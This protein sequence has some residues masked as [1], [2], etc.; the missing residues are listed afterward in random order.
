MNTPRVPP[1]AFFTHLFPSILFPT[2]STRPTTL[3]YLP[4]STPLLPSIHHLHNPFLYGYL[5]A[6]TWSAASVVPFFRSHTR[7]YFIPQSSTRPR[8]RTSPS[9]P[10]S[11]YSVF[12][13]HTAAAYRPCPTEYWASTVLLLPLST[14]D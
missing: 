5:V 13:A 2:P 7:R 4:G 8:P 6:R 1:P 10:G 12:I 11:T 3:G 14:L 9:G